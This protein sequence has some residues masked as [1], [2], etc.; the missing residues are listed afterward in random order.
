MIV[1]EFL[2]WRRRR[3][4]RSVPLDA[5]A[6]AGIMP[7]APDPTAPRDNRDVMG[8]RTALAEDVRFGGAYL[9]RQWWR[10][11]RTQ[12]TQK[13]ALTFSVHH[14]ATDPATMVNSPMR[15]GQAVEIN[16]AAGRLKAPVGNSRSLT[17]TPGERIVLSLDTSEA[18][19]TDE[20]LLRVARSVVPD[21][22]TFTTPVRWR[23]LPAGW[24]VWD[25]T[26]E[27]PP[28]NPWYATVRVR[29]M[30]RTGPTG[31]VRFEVGRAT[32]IP[33]GG[34]RLTVGGRPARTVLLDS[35]GRT[36]R[37]RILM[38][39]PVGGVYVT[40]FGTGAAT[41]LDVLTGFAE[42]TVVTGAGV[43]WLGTR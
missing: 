7:P 39:G 26:I 16:G 9:A 4:A 24:R 25:S 20:D 8:R 11:G 32:G 15:P 35:G 41:D 6:L 42:N 14:A 18:T 19:V 22:G 17:W 29:D 33:A 3:A 28:R 31:E 30:R 10:G 36:D 38:V 1:N 2:S 21:R 40:L 23:S 5:E 43:D 12:T 13:P 27:G 34:T 37:W